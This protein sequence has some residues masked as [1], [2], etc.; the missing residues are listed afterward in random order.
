[1]G[2][3]TRAAQSALDTVL[4]QFGKTA[5]QKLAGELFAVSNAISSSKQLQTTLADPAFAAEEKQRL[6][7]LLF[8]QLSDNAHAI[9]QSVVNSKW[10]K[11]SDLFLGLETAGV[12]VASVGN[13]RT[14]VQE[15]YAVRSVVADNAELE[16]ALND[17]LAQPE[18]KSEMFK[19]VFSGKISE[20]TENII[21]ALVKQQRKRRFRTL[22]QETAET[23]ATLGQFS[24]AQVVSA[25]ALTN[26][27]IAQ[28]EKDLSR[29]Q[30]G[31]VQ[32]IPSIDP[33]AIGGIRIHIGQT[34]LDGTLQ[35]RLAELKRQLAA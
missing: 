1:M 21:S 10:S 8:P 12:K 26:D 34:V 9:V 24:I 7:S 23:V 33:S 28:I 15:L 31:A 4:Q 13:E 11:R 27:Q 30:D 32:I 25:Q 5:D 29:L 35:A 19:K 14:V 2:S 6:V 22:I 16:L 20:A 17:K 18:A 3:A